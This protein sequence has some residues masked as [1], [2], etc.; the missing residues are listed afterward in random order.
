M[1]VKLNG[2]KFKY[3]NGYKLREK[4]RPSKAQFNDKILLHDLQEK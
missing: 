3:R 2:N 1:K 4:V